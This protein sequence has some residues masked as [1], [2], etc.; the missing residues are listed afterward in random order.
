MPIINIGTH[1]SSLLEYST[2]Q[3]NAG[4]N[5][6]VTAFYNTTEYMPITN[7]NSS[8]APIIGITLLYLAQDKTYTSTS[9]STSSSPTPTGS[10][11]G[12]GVSSSF[13]HAAA[14]MVTSGPVLI[15]GAMGAMV[16]LGFA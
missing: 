2:R 8:L 4:D 6:T 1:I 16:A 5:L 10:G 12:S 7:T 13:S 9:T 15:A 14:A 3:I 11:S